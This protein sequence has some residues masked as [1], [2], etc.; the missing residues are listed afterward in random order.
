MADRVDLP[1]GWRGL[2]LRSAEVEVVLLPEKGCDVY[3]WVD[4]E[5]GV[6][7]LFKTPWGLPP[8]APGAT[9]DST[10]AWLERYPGG[11]QVLCPNGGA[12]SAAPGVRWGFHGEACL[13]P[14][15]VVDTG[16]D[17]AELTVRLHRAPLRLRRRVTLSGRLLTIEE[18]VTNTSPDAV[19]LM[20]SHHPAFGSPFLGPDCV[21]ATSAR[22]VLADDEAPGT[23]LAPGSRHAWPLVSTRDGAE[24]DLSVVP[25][26]PAA[27]LAYLTDLD[28]GWF[29]IT[30]ARLG[31]GVGL[32]WPVEVFG[33]AWF[34]QELN[35]S[36]GYP[37]WREAYVCAVEPASTIP[38]Q[39]VD[40]ARRKGSGLV[41]LA[42]GER[43]D[44]T[45][46][47]VM[48]P[49]AGRVRRIGPHGLVE[50]ETEQPE[51]T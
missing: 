29:A 48:F 34:W 43:R 47:A 28:E 17:R 36:A 45:L 15:E 16:P 38:G 4:R 22:T 50:T 10:T 19:E 20:W 37:W 26:A 44:V 9:G 24:L 12:D 5:S 39:G 51:G 32:R 40:A 13:V 23:L 35:S 7:V 6:D 41:R 8:T 27:Q 31:F 2:A 46:E 3:S 11:W 33:H 25:A 49:A 14:W 30:N 21:I 42:G 18:S 1:R